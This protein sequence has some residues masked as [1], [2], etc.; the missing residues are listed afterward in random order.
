MVAKKRRLFCVRAWIF[1][2]LSCNIGRFFSYLAPVKHLYLML[3]LVPLAWALGGCEFTPLEPAT[4]YRP[5]LMERSVLEE[6][7]RLESPRPVA[8]MAKWLH[9]PP[10]LV[11]LEA[12]KGLHLYDNSDPAAPR[13][14]GFVKVPG[15]FNAVFRGAHLV[16]DNAVDLLVLDVFSQP[17]S[18]LVLSR[19]RGVLPEMPPPDLKALPEAFQAAN[20]PE[21]TV[22][23]RWEKSGGE[24]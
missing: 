10:Y 15:C 14:L 1:S 8:E 3:F 4:E 12:Y 9:H 7:V 16:V 19:L 24:S 18:V 20:R 13:A 21:N 6:S 17:D 11:L 23:V 22:I 5:I 2:F